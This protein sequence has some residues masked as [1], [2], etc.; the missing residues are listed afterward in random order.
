VK[1]QGQSHQEYKEGQAALSLCA[2][3]AHVPAHPS[4]EVNFALSKQNKQTNKKLRN[5]TE[6]KIYSVHFFKLCTS[7]SKSGQ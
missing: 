4:A 7:K 3:C 1:R 2:C 5:A 6:T